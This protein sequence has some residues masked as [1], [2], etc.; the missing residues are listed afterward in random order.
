MATTPPTIFFG[1][2][3][4]VDGISDYHKIW[5][6]QGDTCVVG[7]IGE[8]TTREIVSNWDM[9]FAD[10]SLESKYRLLG[11]A[12]QVTS[13]VTTQTKLNS[14]QVWAGNQPYTFNLAMKLRSF[15][16]SQDAG[17]RGFEV[18]KAIEAIE[19]FMAPNLEAGAITDTVLEP[20]LNSRVPQPVDINIGRQVVLTNC[21]IR[22][23]STAYDREK[24]KYGYMLRA[25]ISLQ[26]ETLE[27]LTKADLKLGYGDAT[28][29]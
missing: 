12:L 28:T 21:I 17:K 6:S 19:L 18:E 24:D 25:D 2:F 4:D 23:L 26:I 11:G 13:G 22:S 16:S 3:A 8:G 1:A 20:S 10:S 5:I 27:A 15:I 14:R 9:P 7:Y 29:E